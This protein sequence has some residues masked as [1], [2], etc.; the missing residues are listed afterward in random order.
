MPEQATLPELIE[1]GISRRLKGLH[2]ACL[3][4]MTSYDSAAYTCSATLAV[5]LD[6]QEVEAL[7][8]VPVLIP[9]AWAA[10]DP[11]LLVFS[12]EDCS[13]WLASGAVAAAPSKRRHGL[14]ASAIP[15]IAREGQTTQFV[16]LAN[17]VNARF[18][19]L[20]TW[21][22]SHIHPTGVGPSGVGAPVLG[23]GDSTAAAKVKAR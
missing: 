16:A 4:Q 17:L 21:A 9:G 12:E 2:T 18:E 6:G 1:A 3:G 19:R 15:L 22:D 13:A 5:T 23:P 8:E 20:E 7:E 10:G 11:V 14:Y